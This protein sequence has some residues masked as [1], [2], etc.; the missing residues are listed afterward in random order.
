MSQEWVFL[1]KN[2]DEKYVTEEVEKFFK[3]SGSFIVRFL[4][5]ANKVNEQLDF[6]QFNILSN[7]NNVVEKRIQFRSTK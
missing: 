5:Q 6:F 1:E 4:F 7:E 2:I 3:K